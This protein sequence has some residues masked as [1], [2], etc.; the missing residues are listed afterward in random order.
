MT[1]F[2]RA[3]RTL[4]FLIL[5][6]SGLLPGLQTLSAQQIQESVSVPPCNVTVGLTAAGST[7]SF[8]NRMLGCAVWAFNYTSQGF[9]ALTIT[10][11]SAP[12]NGGTPGTWVTFAGTIVAGSNP[13]TATTQGVVQLSGFYPWMR[14]T[15]SGT[16]GSGTVRGNLYGY[17]YSAV[18]VGGSTPTGPAGGALTGTYPNPT[19]RNL[20][21]L[22]A[23]P[24]V[25]ST[26]V[27]NNSIQTQT[28]TV[29]TVSGA[30]QTQMG[31]NDTGLSRIVRS[32][33][34]SESKRIVIAGSSTAA[35]VGASTYALSWAG[36]FTTAMTAKGYTVINMSIS[37]NSVQAMIDRFYTDI[38][39]LNPDIVIHN[40]GIP[41]DG[42]NFTTYTANIHRIIQMTQQIGAIPILGSQYGNNGD[43]ATICQQKQDLRDY[44]NK[45]GIATIDFL[46]ATADFASNC[47]WYPGTFADAIHPNDAGH[48]AMFSAIPL[49]LFDVLVSGYTPSNRPGSGVW[50]WGIATTGSPLLTTLNSATDS[51]TWSGWMKG[52]T[53][54]PFATFSLTGAVQSS[55][56]LRVRC[57][58][59]NDF[60]QLTGS[61]VG[62]VSSVPC[63]D[64]QF[65]HLAIVYVNGSKTIQFYVNGSLVGSQASYTLPAVQQFATLYRADGN[66]FIPAA[67]GQISQLAIWRTPLSASQILA[68][69]NGRIQ[70]A[71]LEYWSN[72]DTAPGP[73]LPNLALSSTTTAVDWTTANGFS[74]STTVRSNDGR[75]ERYNQFPSANTTSSISLDPQVQTYFCDTTGGNITLVLPFPFA[76]LQVAI[77]NI[78]TNTCNLSSAGGT[79]INGSLTATLQPNESAIYRVSFSFGSGKWFSFNG[80]TNELSAING[81]IGQGV[82]G[83]GSDGDVTIP[84]GTTTL[85]RDMYYNNLSFTGAAPILNPAGY[86]IFV[87]GTLNLA[88]TAAGGIIRTGNNGGN[89]SGSSFGTGGSAVATFAIPGGATGVSGAAGTTGA[90]A[91]PT[92]G[93]AV[94]LSNG[95]TGGTGGNGGAGTPNA[96]GSGQTA[97]VAADSRYIRYWTALLTSAAVISGGIGGGGGA[98]GGGDGAN[99]GGGGG[100][101]G[102]GAPVIWISAR[103]INRSTLGSPS[104]S[105]IG[106]NGGNGGNGTGGNTGGGGGGGGAGGGF[107]Y[108]AYGNLTGSTATNAISV[109]GGNGGNGGTGQGTGIGG[110]GGN[111]GGGGTVIQLNIGTGVASVFNGGA[112]TAG[113]AGVGTVGGTGGAG[114]TARTNL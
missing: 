44:F 34:T 27:L 5:T 88:G 92:G 60:W 8:D 32:R 28:S 80:L 102:S 95:G 39:P 47:A 111:G 56:A 91:T 82:F 106:G 30:T 114:A 31:I 75:P 38:A 94:A 84:N 68:V 97:I 16:T 63:G 101:S 1:T 87:R 26:G 108:I 81:A 17:K 20:T 12:D 76:G 78:G 96:G 71:S 90:G 11:Q 13:Q 62:I 98:S 61:T 109:S 15:L 25:S 21:T 36:L 74:R 107:V 41:N 59:S 48:Q 89:A 49:S 23:V 57:P 43:T 99:A 22:N 9:S 70:A 93:T 110:S 46:S 105:S 45:S 83:D 18:N 10:V 40:T 2:S 73:T 42:N 29:N 67:G 69:Y 65:V 100:G 54:F 112:G 37:G 72:F 86:R 85:T 4:A 33:P 103:T 55:T 51:W 3:F 35:G 53:G 77:R 113:T 58:G 24:L 104:I 19:L 79:T 66:P 50:E 6:L 52:G 14:V 64:Q 7:A